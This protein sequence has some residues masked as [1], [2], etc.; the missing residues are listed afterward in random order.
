MKKWIVVLGLSALTLGCRNT[1][2]EADSQIIED[3]KIGKLKENDT[4]ALQRMPTGLATWMSYYQDKDKDFSVSHFKASGVSLHFGDLPDAVAPSDEKNLSRYYIY[5]PDSS[6]YLD[7]FSYDHFINKGELVEG[8]ADQQ[9]V[10]GVRGSG[11]RKQVLFS[12]PSQSIDFAD[13][14]G[15]ESFILGLTSVNEEGKTLSAQLM[16]FRITDSSFTNFD[17][18]HSIPLDSVILSDKRF[19]EIY[20]NKLKDR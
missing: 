7:L 2:K 11:I 14:T 13:W 9:V 3:D 8:E 5:S 1:D 4:L 16:L 18:D 12:G 19:S 17:L 10:L 6:R 15:K 20:I